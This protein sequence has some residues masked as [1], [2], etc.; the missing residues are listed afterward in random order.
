MRLVFFDFNIN[1]GGGPQGSV[2]LAE[3]LSK[4]NEV[5]I[6]DAYGACDLYC[7]AIRQTGVP[8]HILYPDAKEVCIG[9]VGKPVKRLNSL[10]KQ[11]PVF[12]Q[13][14][15][16]LTQKILEINPDVIWVKN[17]KS[18]TLLVSCLR[19]YKYPV[20]VYE[21]GWATFDQIKGYYRLLLKYKV[22]AIMAHSRAT[23]RQLTLRGIPESKLHYA[24]N[25]ID[26]E[27]IKQ[28]A[29]KSLDS[30]LSMTNK[31]PKILL[32]TA[33]F[34]RKK[35]H[36]AAV[37]T[38]ALLKNDG[39]APVLLLPGKIGTGVS[40]VFR[41]ELERNIEQ[42]KLEDNVLFIGWCENMPALIR[43]S[44]IVIL[45]THTE[46][47]PRIVLE[48]MLLKRPV[49]ATPVGGVPEAIEDGKTGFLFPVDDAQA[50]ANCI[51]KLYLEPQT[52][53]TI[54]ENAYDLVMNEFSSDVHTE[55]VTTMFESIINNNKK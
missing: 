28:D 40:N 15:R 36:L 1:Y 49:C 9:N 16:S 44:D 45:P 41:E 27:K 48:S 46:G 12:V 47:F 43:A 52:R 11:I 19:L 26:K 51:K 17:K 24:Q 37:K 22:S 39:Y 29:Q 20:A 4:D 7:Q 34:E 32:P 33:R 42:L 54:V 50:L 38:L 6:I 8:L 21:R 31:S 55:T 35:G 2:Y 18:M 10:I 25:T 23:I 5:H 3:R 14:Q 13:L 53:K 30:P